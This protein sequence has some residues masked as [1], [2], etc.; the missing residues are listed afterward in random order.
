[1]PDIDTRRTYPSMAD[2]IADVESVDPEAAE[3]LRSLSLTGT[4]RLRCLFFW[5]CTPQGFDFWRNLEIRL[6]TPQT[7]YADGVPISYEHPGLPIT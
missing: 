5:D 6:A 2:L 4:P 3:Y 7:Y 1:M